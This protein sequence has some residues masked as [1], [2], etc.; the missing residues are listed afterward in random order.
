MYKLMNIK[1]Y[2]IHYIHYTL[3][4]AVNTNIQLTGGAGLFFETPLPV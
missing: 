2:T 1:L 3:Y 4:T